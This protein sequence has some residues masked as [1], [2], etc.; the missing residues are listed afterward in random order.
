[1]TQKLVSE[2]QKLQRV[3]SEPSRGGN[4]TAITHVPS[5]NLIL[6]EKIGALG[7]VV[8]NVATANQTLQKEV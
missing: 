3:R 8:S 4:L 5:E 7:V 6:A 1:M 2:G